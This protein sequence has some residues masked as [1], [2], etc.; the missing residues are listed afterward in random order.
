M[1]EEQTSP[2]ATE[3]T[4]VAAPVL[5]TVLAPVPNGAPQATEDVE[6]ADSAPSTAATPGQLSTPTDGAA[7]ASAPVPEPQA[8]QPQAQPVKQDQ[9]PAA[10]PL[11]APSPAPPAS[12]RNSP[13]PT[14][15]VHATAPVTIHGAPTRQYLNKHVTP[16]LL[17]AM[18]RLATAEPPPKKPLLWLS[19]F[20]AQ[21]SAELEG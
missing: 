17:E 14:G 16:S 7:I 6:M 9:Q 12:T 21:K 5:T 3:P 4:T 15:S 1:A 8:Q 20:L 11:S 13:H 2:Q 18:K 10:A 19:E